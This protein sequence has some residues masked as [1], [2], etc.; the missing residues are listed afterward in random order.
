MGAYAIT[1]DQV[2]KLKEYLEKKGGNTLIIKN[3]IVKKFTSKEDNK[4]GEQITTVTIDAVNLSNKQIAE[5][6][7]CLGREMDMEISE[8]IED[9]NGQQRMNLSV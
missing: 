7:N 5:L 4:D 2:E 6:A 8:S 9:R 1:S 3:C